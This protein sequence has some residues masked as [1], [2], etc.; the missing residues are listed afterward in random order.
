VVG[1]GSWVGKDEAEVARESALLLGLAS[2]TAATVL[3][4]AFTADRG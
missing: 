4:T 1:S 2:S 3:L